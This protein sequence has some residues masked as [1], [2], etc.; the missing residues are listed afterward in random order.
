MTSLN[1]DK[2]EEELLEIEKELHEYY[3]NI[4]LSRFTKPGLLRYLK[5]RKL[6]NTGSC[7]IRI[8][9]RLKKAALINNV[10]LTDIQHEQLFSESMRKLIISFDLNEISYVITNLTQSIKFIRLIY[11]KNN[12]EKKFNENQMILYNILWTTYARDLDVLF[13]LRKR[14][15]IETGKI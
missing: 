2:V 6:E 11:I 4:N 5:L 10:K 7:D 13:E 8:Q 15:I 14:I 3:L 1:D 9:N 12:F